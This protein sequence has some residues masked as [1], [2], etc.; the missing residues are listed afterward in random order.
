MGKKRGYGARGLQI[1]KV[2]D[3]M[4]QHVSRSKKWVR[5]GEKW[6]V[7]LWGDRRSGLRGPRSDLKGSAE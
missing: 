3:R 5:P 7:S 1:K 4:D 6:K 2:Q